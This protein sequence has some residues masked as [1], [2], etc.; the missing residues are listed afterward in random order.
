M[1]YLKFKNN[2]KIIKE[3]TEN[4]ILIRIENLKNNYFFEA[5]GGLRTNQNI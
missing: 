1:I 5:K 3:I 2:K 4:F